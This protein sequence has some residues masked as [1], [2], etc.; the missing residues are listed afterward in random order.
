MLS[1]ESP[2]NS[3]FCLNQSLLINSFSLDDDLY[4]SFRAKRMLLFLYALT[5]I[6][7]NKIDA[8]IVNLFCP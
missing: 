2:I 6:S 4:F 7:Y 5:Y 1:P 3:F 8:C